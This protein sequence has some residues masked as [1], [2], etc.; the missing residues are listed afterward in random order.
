[1]KNGLTL[2][3]SR[4]KNTR[5]TAITVNGIRIEQKGLQTTNGIIYL[6]DRMLKP[7]SIN[8]VQE[9]VANEARLTFF[10][11]AI[12]RSGMQ[13]GLTSA[14]LHTVFA[15]SN[16]AFVSMGITTT[17]SIYKMNPVLLQQIVKSHIAAGRN[18]IYDYIMKADPS[19]DAYL[20]EMLN[21]TNATMQLLPS[22]DRPDR[23]RGVTVH[24]VNATGIETQAN[25]IDDNLAAANGVVHII[26]KL[27]IP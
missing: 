26:D 11:A 8:N 23:F 6:L 3:V 17:D 19:T 16:Q 18:F 27:F 10:N 2:F 21:G 15:P 25:I 22:A 1:M 5:D 14:N 13:S 20:E 9:V 4:R 24:H 12:L 7:T